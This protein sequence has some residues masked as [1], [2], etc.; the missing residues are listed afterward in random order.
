M[1]PNR[2]RVDTS[3]LYRMFWEII[4]L[5]PDIFKINPDNT[6]MIKGLRIKSLKTDVENLSP[7]K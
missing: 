5:N 4:S 3:P 6:A 1:V 7:E 2:S